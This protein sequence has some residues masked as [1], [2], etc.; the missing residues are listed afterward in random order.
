MVSHE[1]GSSTY[2]RMLG[3]FEK[4][5]DGD[6][7]LLE[8]ARLRFREAGLGMECHA[9]TTS[10]LEW[11]LGLRPTPEAPV[12]AHLSRSIDLFEERERLRVM[13]FARIFRGRIYGLVVHDQKEAA[14]RFDDYV[15]IAQLLGDAL[16]NIEGSPYLFLEYAS[17]LESGLFVKLFRKLKDSRLLSACVDIGHLGLWRVREAYSSRYPG[18][19]ICAI[20][21]DDVELPHIIEDVQSAVLTAVDHVVQVTGELAALGKPLHF[22]LHDGHPLSTF[23]A[24]DVSDHLSFLSEI[25]IPFDYGGRQSLPPMF[26]PAGLAEIAGEA[27]RLLG[28]ELVSFLLEVHPTEGRIPL[29]N[30]DYLFMNWQDKLNAERMNFWLSTLAQNRVLLSEVCSRTSVSA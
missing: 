5:I 26:G 2:P 16:Q 8:L 19:D 4:K 18:K 10:E 17:G 3:L 14:D 13:D 24:Y 29:G 28:P 1:V 20:R 25:P 15:A 9:E 7:A 30:A 22:H 12:T 11:F 6:D 21:P 23:S 27:L